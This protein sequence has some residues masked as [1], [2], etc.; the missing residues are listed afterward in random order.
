[1]NNKG[2]IRLYRKILDNPVVNKDNDYLSIFIYLL[3]SATHSEIKANFKGEIITLKPGQLITGRKTLGEKCRVQEMKV[4]RILKALEN[5]QQIEQQKSNKNR[6]ISI[7]NWNKYQIS[8]QLNEQQMNN[9]RTTNEQQMNTN[10]NVNNVINSYYCYLEKEYAR[11]I[12]STECEL[13]DSLLKTYDQDLVKEAIK[14]SIIMNRKNLNYVK[15]ILKNWKSEGKN[16]VDDLKNTEREDNQISSE[17]IE[18]FDSDW[19]NDSES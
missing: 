8:E 7:V 11:T 14:Q 19:L 1:M 12:S 5:E 17:L 10:N 2:Y 4:E 3:L 16:T 6:L 9:K 13:L 15:G 18:L